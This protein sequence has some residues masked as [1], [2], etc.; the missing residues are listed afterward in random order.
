[1]EAVG[2]TSYAFKCYAATRL[3]NCLA[4]DSA[5][6]F[7]T[8]QT[9]MFLNCTAVDNTTY[10]FQGG[11]NAGCILC[12]GAGNGTA[13]FYQIYTTA[14][15]CLNTSADATAPGAGSVTGFLTSDFVDY[16]G[17]DF[18]LKASVKDTTKARFAG[19]PRYPRDGFGQT[20]KTGGVIYAGWFDPDPLTAVKPSAPA[21]AEA[22]PGDGQ[23][24]LHVTAAAELDVIYAR[25]RTT[26][27]SPG[28]SAESETFKRTGSGNITVT[29]LVNGA[30]YEFAAYAKSGDLTSDWTAPVSAKPEGTG[31]GT[32]WTGVL[33]KSS[34]YWEGI[35]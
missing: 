33:V 32:A 4:R 20:K 7:F 9:A 22:V 23:V 12:I 16:A 10:G 11:N 30:I 6:G 31:P 19:Y 28:W 25:Y 3:I 17:N 35:L 18:R 27:P 1:L 14:V 15:T 13:D 21:I 2:G 29:G 24:I 34:A 8:D 26:C 5:V